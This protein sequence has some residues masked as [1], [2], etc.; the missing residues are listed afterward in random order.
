MGRLEFIF[1]KVVIDTPSLPN[2]SHKVHQPIQVFPALASSWF[3]LLQ[4]AKRASF[5]LSSIVSAS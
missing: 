5:P 2:L 4:K 1:T 3:T